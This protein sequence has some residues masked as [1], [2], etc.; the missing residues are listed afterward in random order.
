MCQKEKDIYGT[1]E[2][3]KIKIFNILLIA[4]AFEDN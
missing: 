2:Y 4:L 1:I 3:L